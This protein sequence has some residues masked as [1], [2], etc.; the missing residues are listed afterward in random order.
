MINAVGAHAQTR[1]YFLQDSAFLH[2]LTQWTRDVGLL[3]V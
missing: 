3:L 1:V 2:S